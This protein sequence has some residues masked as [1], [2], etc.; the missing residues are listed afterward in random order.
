MGS[1]SFETALRLTEQRDYHELTR[2]LVRELKEVKHA[3]A[4]NIFELYGVESRMSDGHVRLENYVIRRFASL[5]QREVAIS[6]EHGL[7]RCLEFGDDIEIDD[8][9]DSEQIRL[10]FPVKGG[11]GP[12]RLVV[13][14]GG[15]ALSRE[16]RKIS[17][18][19]RL[20]RHQVI[21]H[22]SR[23][24]DL[25]TGLLNR[26]TFDSSVLKVT[27]YFLKTPEAH[28]P[29]EQNWLAVLDIDHFKRINDQ[30]GHLYGD[31]VLLR[32]AH[33]MKQT[34][35]YTDMA[36]RFGGEE[37]IVILT[38]VDS[39][40]VFSALERF[41]NSVSAFDFG[42]AGQVTVSIGYVAIDPSI[43][44][45]TLVDRADHALYEAKNQGRNRT[46]MYSGEEQ[47]LA[48]VLDDIELF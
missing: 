47:S 30:L 13:I 40:G 29:H 15:R 19:V 5:P 33:L 22:D 9:E 20:Y 45:S 4:V 21:L 16:R 28:S 23:E 36:F 24:R 26:Q 31:E 10:V 35:R 43:L 41:R 1:P 38:E 3:S 37:F 6:T 17:Q 48:A 42:A 34:F 11:I 12:T 25:L 46:L 2:C 8:P 18:V 39:E 14:D 7:V 44:P 27:E 32:F